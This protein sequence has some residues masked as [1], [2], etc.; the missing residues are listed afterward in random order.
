MALQHLRSNTASKRPT[1]A[2]MADGQLAINTSATSPGLFFKD[3]GGALIK[4][5]PVHVGT[6]APN[7][8]PAG[9]SGNAIGEQWLDTSGGGYVFKVWDGSA[10]RSEAG[11]FVDAAGDTMTGALILP[12]G[13]EAAPALGVGST[14]NGIYS[15]GA[16]QVAIST[17]GTGRLFVDANGNVGVGAVQNT[18]KFNVLTGTSNST[19][20]ELTGASAGRG[21]KIST[22]ANIANDAGVLIEAPWANYGQLAFG[23]AGAERVRIDSSGRLGLGTSS[24]GALFHA[25]GSSADIFIQDTQA[26]TTSSGPL[27]QFQGRGPNATNYNFGYIRG[28]SS[29]SNNAGI[30]QFATNSAGTQSVAMTIDSSQR[31]GIGTTS[32]S[33]ILSVETA[34]TVDVDRFSTANRIAYF[35]TSLNAGNQFGQIAIKG[36]HGA[37]INFL[38]GYTGGETN[39]AGIFSDVSDNLRFTTGGATE[40]ARLDSSGRLGLGTSS[41]Q[42]LLHVEGGS[43]PTIRLRTSTLGSNAS[44]ASTYI[45]FRGFNQ[46]IRARIEVQDRRSNVL[47]GFLNIGTANTSNVL[48]NAIHIDSSQRVGIGTTSPAYQCVVEGSTPYLQLKQTGTNTGSS[49][50]IFG[51][52]DTASPG[53]IIYDHSDSSLQAVVSG[54]ERARI[55]SSGRLLVGTTTTSAAPL[56]VNGTVEANGSLYRAV[57]GNGYLDGDSSGAGGLNSAEVQIQSASSNRPA[58]LSL[59]GGQGSGEALGVISFFNSNNTDGKRLRASIACGQE[60]ATANEQGG[61]LVF[62]TTKDGASSPTSKLTINNAGLFKI[63][64]QS[65][66]ATNTYSSEGGY[67]KHYETNDIGT[68]QRTL[69]IASLGDGTYGSNIRFLTNVNSSATATERMRIG[70]DGGA[71]FFGD[72][73]K[74]LI[75]SSTANAANT[76]GILFRGRHTATSTQNGTDCIFIY[77]N[78]NVVNTNDSY[79]PLVSDIKY[80]ENIVDAG[81]QWNDFKA[82]KFRKFNFK[83]ETGFETFTQ[84]GVIA[85]EV[86][87]VSPGL[88]IE[89]P[90]VDEN[91]NE[92]GTTT[93]TV[94]S[95]VLTKKALIAL[96]EAMERIEVLE[97]RLAD[98]G[99]A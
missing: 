51:D 87:L 21:L 5:G 79:G 34:G 46:E 45:D 88:V 27:L 25:A 8:S 40:R 22:Y 54:A 70:S 97:Q 94:K 96:Q 95:S 31:V 56:T 47:G 83:P 73:G 39:S 80:K 69:D 91:G 72:S 28:V 24:P 60:G 1:P 55:D 26:F 65:S 61:L 77:A 50:V 85:Q 68:A 11:E 38:R 49:R 37:G 6:S 14:D 36:F 30:L 20:M 9:S 4:V 66:Q 13:T 33:Q 23:T 58:I 81:S 57:F 62:S 16:D 17:N 64:Q 18:S 78:G 84:L 12:S 75:H 82:I 42:D 99:I 67:V 53:Q 71:Y 15:P 43:S 90:D 48:T 59:G 86:E 92:L 41:P 76:S 32:P 98:A 2:S 10:W 19:I 7:S 29:G 93:K 74:T 89:T 63:H 44:P 52:A 3:A 35:R